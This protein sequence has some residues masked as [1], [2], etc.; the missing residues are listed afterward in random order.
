MLG[1]WI[2]EVRLPTRCRISL[3]V[4]G[5][6]DGGKWGAID[7]VL[8]LLCHFGQEREGACA[9]ISPDIA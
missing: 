7:A 5:T 9:D 1:E 4:A 2:A 8:S 6:L 3:V